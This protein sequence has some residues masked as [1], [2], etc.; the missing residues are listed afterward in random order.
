M[1]RI[2]ISYATGDDD[3]VTQLLDSLSKL[4]NVETC[5]PKL[6]SPSSSN[7]SCKI[8]Q[9]LDSSHAMIAMITFNS[10]NSMWLNQQIGYAFAKNIPIILIVEKGIDVQGFLENLDSITY[11]R[12]D[13]NRNIYEIICKMREIFSNDLS[14]LSINNFYVCCPVC[15]KIII[16]SLPPNNIINEKI[17]SGTNL[18]YKC[19]FCSNAIKIN[20][21][22]L[23]IS[24]N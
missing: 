16:E 21:M 14:E 1:L 9:N 3:F 22:T 23:S 20:P 17:N 6:I 24:L 12:G 4:V 15:N 2:F 7:M 8:K 13:F 19:K 18:S 11:H 10:T 5:V